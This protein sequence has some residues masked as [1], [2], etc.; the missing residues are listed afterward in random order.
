[1]TGNLNIIKI[2]EQLRDWGGDAPVQPQSTL[3][4]L[5]ELQLSDKHEIAVEEY[6]RLI[7]LMRAVF[8]TFKAKYD[9]NIAKR[10][11]YIS[12]LDKEIGVMEGYDPSD[13]QAKDVKLLNGTTTIMIT[14]IKEMIESWMLL[15]A[16]HGKREVL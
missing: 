1:M 13:T 14:V 5:N 9:K 2:T 15:R 11:D 8:T 6:K 4:L 10:S 3:R 12:L 16:N 7:L